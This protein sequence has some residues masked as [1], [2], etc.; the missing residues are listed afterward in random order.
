[1]HLPVFITECDPSTRGQGWN[2]SAN[3]GW[4]RAAYREIAEWNRDPTHQPI[5]ALALYRW[6]VLPDQPEWSISNRPGIIEDFRQALQLEPAAD[7]K[8]RL[9]VKGQPP[10]V[11]EPGNL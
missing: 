6:P 8:V 2:P 1:R 3:V 10:T 7:F 4:V 11:L 9:P 5:L